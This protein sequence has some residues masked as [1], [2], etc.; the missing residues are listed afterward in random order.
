VLPLVPAVALAPLPV[1]GVGFVAL[2]PEVV[3]AVLPVAV[4]PPEE[5][6][7][8]DPDVCALV[9]MKSSS[10]ELAAPV[11]PLVP[12]AP[13]VPLDDARWMHPVTVT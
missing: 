9:R 11:V 5:Y 7:P 2:V 4:L 6:A 12:V 8:E 1:V 10:V 13:V 3:P